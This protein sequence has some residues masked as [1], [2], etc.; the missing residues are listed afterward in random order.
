MG[1]T[2]SEVVQSCRE[3]VNTR[4]CTQ[5]FIELYNNVSAFDKNNVSRV[6]VLRSPGRL[7]LVKCCI[8]RA[9]CAICRTEISTQAIWDDIRVHNVCM[10]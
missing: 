7:G 2:S 3:A 6:C 4:A 1:G 9:K 10:Y 5:E 8:N